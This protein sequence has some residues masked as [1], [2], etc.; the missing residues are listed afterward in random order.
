MCRVC[1][2]GRLAGW[3]EEGLGRGEVGKAWPSRPPFA[4]KA[5]AR[6]SELVG[7]KRRSLHAICRMP[8]LENRKQDSEKSAG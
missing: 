6:V 5:R 1:A 2:E 3:A 4:I 7:C 8:K